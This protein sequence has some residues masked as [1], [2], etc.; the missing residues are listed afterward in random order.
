MMKAE[1][2]WL[3]PSLRTDQP[4][5]GIVP[6]VELGEAISWHTRNGKKLPLW[7]FDEF[8]AIMSLGQPFPGWLGRSVVF[9]ATHSNA[10]KQVFSVPQE[11]TGMY[12][13]LI[14]SGGNGGNGFTGAA[15]AS[16]GGGGGGGSGAITRIFMPISLIGNQIYIYAGTPGNGTAISLIQST[17]AID[18]IATAGT[19]GAGGNGTGA[20]GGGAG[21]AGSALGATAHPMLGICTFNSIAGTAGA[22]G[23]AQT[24]AVGGTASFGTGGL[25]LSG[26]GGGGGVSGTDQAGGPVNTGG[27]LANIAGGAAGSNEGNAGYNLERPFLSTGGSGGGSSNTGVGGA[28]G[29]GGVGS[30]GGGGGGGTTGG[31]GGRGGNGRVILLLMN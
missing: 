5:F 12:A 18:V 1:K 4:K 3:P 27:R 16:R 19:G 13:I 28:G 20:A 22:A 15:A 23:G 14:G 26:G 9:N 2:L 24:G 30:G 17:A 21:S 11:T 31:A 6:R 10:D 29:A 7:M 25:P 8:E